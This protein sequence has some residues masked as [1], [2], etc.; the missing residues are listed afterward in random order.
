MNKKFFETLKS[1]KPGGAV[2]NV[3]GK[4]LSL[5]TTGV[6][7]KH[8][9]NCIFCKSGLGENIREAVKIRSIIAYNLHNDRFCEVLD[10]VIKGVR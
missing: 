7:E 8:D 4:D 1:L 10:L 3:F 9:N 5:L 2:I 6:F